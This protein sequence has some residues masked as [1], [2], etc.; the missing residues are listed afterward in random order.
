MTGREMTPQERLDESGALEPLGERQLK[1]VAEPVE[2]W[3]IST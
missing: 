2:C 1:N 3:A